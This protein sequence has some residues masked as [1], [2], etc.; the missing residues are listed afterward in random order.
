MTLDRL[1]VSLD[2]TEL[3][4]EIELA[5]RLIIACSQSDGPLSAA[6]IDALLG[7][8]PARPALKSVPPPDPEK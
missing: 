4:A 6:D 8:P 2:D 5:S 3:L 7:L 1:D